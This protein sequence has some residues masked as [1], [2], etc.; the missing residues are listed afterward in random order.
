MKQAVQ[1][2]KK[3]K[4]S[5]FRIAMC[6]H[7]FACIYSVILAASIFRLFISFVYFYMN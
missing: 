2:G 3:I 1:P 7:I 6:E 5:L 4:N